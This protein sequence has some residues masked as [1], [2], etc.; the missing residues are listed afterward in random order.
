[1]AAATGRSTSLRYRFGRFE[2]DLR[3]G[4][5]QRDGVTV[6]LQDQPLQ[7]LRLLV[8]R[9]GDIVTR[10]ELRRQVWTDDIHVD[11]DPGLNSIVRR[12]RDALEDSAESPTYIQTVPRRGYRL[13]VTPHAVPA[14]DMPELEPVKPAEPAAAVVSSPVRAWVVAAG[15][16]IASALV[17]YAAFRDGGRR[18]ASA[19][20]PMRLAVLPFENL[21]DGQDQQFFAD[22]L[23]E[24][25]IARLGRVQPR[26]L[27]VV[28]RTSVMRYRDAPK[29]VAAIARELGVDF[30]LEGSVRHAGDRIRVTTRLIRAADQFQLWSE[31]YDRSWNDVFAIQSDV[32][33]RVADSLAVELVPTALAAS[34]GAP[35]R[36]KAYEHYLKGR[37]YWNQRAR[38]PSAQLANAIE[39]FRLAIA[40]QPD[41]ARAYAGLADAQ[42]SI[43]FANPALGDTPSTS[44]RDALR[45]ALQLDPRLAGAHSTL[46]WMSMHFDHDLAEAEQAFD[47]ALELDP[48]DSLTRFRYA[49]LLAVRGRLPQAER[50]AEAARQADPLSAT[51]ADIQ[52]WL[53]YYGGNHAVALQRF[54]EASELEGNPTRLHLFSGFLRAMADDCAGAIAELRPWALDPETLRMAEAVYARAK[55]EEPAS[56]PDLERALLERRLTYS[57]AM[58]HF[59]RRDMSAFYEWLNRAIDE[60]FPEPLYLAV[61]PV[62]AS[63]RRDP[64]FLAA[65][66]RVGL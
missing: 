26:Q 41:Y 55:C 19:R 29:A 42:N 5:L 61:D 47:R 64:R 56:L 14:V 25:M 2:L 21:S 52:G 49:H 58:F 16:A 9:A 44:A 63:E 20:A 39:E 10:E 15:L 38:N 66:R 35:V 3:S 37:F 4:E 48:S 17:A 50:E 18:A 30:V 12:L 36:S 60:R 54:E 13:L 27:T 33:A 59:A 65:L 46:A 1:M 8:E 11:F 57:T 31:S 23:H 7:V 6:P 40:E 53:A 32:S 43:F 24:E 34:A 62:F 45:R 22:G 51:I 28:A